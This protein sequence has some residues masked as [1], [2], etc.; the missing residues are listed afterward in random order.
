MI[1][2]R[3]VTAF[4][5]AS[6]ANVGCGFDIMGFA[7][8]DIGDRVTVSVLP[9]GDNENVILG[10]DFGHL[11]PVARNKNTAGVA[12][13]AYLQA[14]GK[15]DMELNIFLE[16]NMPLGSGMGSSASSSAAAVF[17]VNHLFGKPLSTRELIPFAMEGER[18]ACGSAHADNVA[19]ALLGGFA[20]I[21]SYQPLDIIP[22][23][24][25]DDL[26]SAIVHPH[27]EL[28][29]SDSRRVLTR[30][31]SVENAIIQS[32]NTAGFMVA[33]LKGDYDLMK[34]SMSDLL[35]EP[36]RMQ[37]IPGFDAIK[38]AAMDAGAV[39][40][41]IAG[42]GPSVFA[43]CRGEATARIVAMAMQA[44]FSDIGLYN[45]AFVSKLN[46]PGTFVVEAVELNK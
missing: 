29:T 2:Y 31:V 12:V 11:T 34:R 4:A 21:R 3:S 19:P 33:L 28:N 40:C 32:A 18:I 39:G 26:Y 27:I 41:G 5:P 24:C 15:S 20:L 44:E 35:A 45:E 46:S 16:K 13:N 23:L 8:E 9:G 37:L 22:L 42:S 1:K 36:K 10:G 30:E 38:I 43:L 25:P 14:I 7:L 6:I 17:A